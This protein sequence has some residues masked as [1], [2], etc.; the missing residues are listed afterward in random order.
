LKK[1]NLIFLFSLVTLSLLSLSFILQP[2]RVD[3]ATDGQVYKQGYVITVTLKSNQELVDS[4]VTFSDARGRFYEVS[5]SEDGYAY[6]ALLGIP[7]DSMT[8]EGFIDVNA[9]F[10]SNQKYKSSIPV[11]SIMKNVS[12]EKLWE[13]EFMM[14]VEGR[15]SSGYGEIR[16]FRDSS[17]SGRHRGVDI[18]AYRGTG[19]SM[20]NNGVVVLCEKFR[21]L[22]NTVLIDHGQGVYS[23]YMHLYKINVKVSDR[24]EKGDVIG[25]VGSTGQSTGPHLHWGVYV[26][27]VSVNPLQWVV[28]EIL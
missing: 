1:D 18:A 25:T 8:G 3:V 28:K 13:N 16:G 11:R 27:G 4:A 22:G 12:E 7:C 6:R 2:L 24:L 15:I 21:G 17:V 20:P 9:I 5:G 14:P 26:N 10:I 23:V 19:I